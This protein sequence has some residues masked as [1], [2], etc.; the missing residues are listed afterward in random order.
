MLAI[1]I[2][3]LLLITAPVMAQDKP[4]KPVTKDSIAMSLKRLADK[5]EKSE[6]TKSLAPRIKRLYAEI[7]LEALKEMAEGK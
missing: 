7:M 3:V 4:K 5:A 1:A 6:A 2:T